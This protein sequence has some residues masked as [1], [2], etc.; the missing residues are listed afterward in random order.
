MQ[1]EELERIIGECDDRNS[2]R[3][4]VKAYAIELIRRLKSHGRVSTDGTCLME[5]MLDGALSWRAYSYGG[6]SLIYEEDIAYRLSDGK[7][8]YCKDGT[9]MRPNPFENWFD[10]QARALEASAEWICNIVYAY[11]LIEQRRFKGE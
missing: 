4:A 7:V 5:E 9:L 6:R 1:L 3:C 2:W 11:E 10:V 8:R